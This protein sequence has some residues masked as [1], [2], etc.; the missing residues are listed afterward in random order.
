MSCRSVGSINGQGEYRPGFFNLGIDILDPI[1]FLLW[2]AA[3]CIVGCL[4]ASPAFT[5]QLSVALSQL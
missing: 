3:L 5:L 4:A 1:I 2:R